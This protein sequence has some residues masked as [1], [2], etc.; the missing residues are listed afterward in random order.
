[1][2]VIGLITIPRHLFR[3]HIGIGS[4]AEE[5]LDDLYI[6]YLAPVSVKGSNIFM[7]GILDSSTNS[8]SICLYE[9]IMFGKRV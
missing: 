6:N 4:I 7:M 2:L 1:M 9:F 5:T 3:S 8:I